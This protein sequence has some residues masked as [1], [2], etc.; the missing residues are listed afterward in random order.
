MSD[1]FD[2]EQNAAM[3][4]E[5]STIPKINNDVSPVTRVRMTGVPGSIAVSEE[6]TAEKPPEPNV[7]QRAAP[8]PEPIKQP[9]RSDQGANLFSTIEKSA[10]EAREKTQRNRDKYVINLRPEEYEKLNRYIAATDD[11]D[12]AE[13]RAYRMAAAMRY[14]EML[15]V[16][17]EHAMQNLDMYNRALLG[18]DAD[19]EGDKG[20][21]YAISDSWWTGVNMIRQGALGMQMMKAELTGDANLAGLLKNEYRALEKDNEAMVDRLPRSW[22]MEMLK[23]GAQSLPFTAGAA[24]AAIV[25][26]IGPA[27]SFGFSALTAAGSEYVELRENGAD[28]KTATIVATLSGSLQG[29]IEVALGDVPAWKNAVKGTQGITGKLTE[30]LFRRIKYAGGWNTIAGMLVR[31][32][33]AVA[34]EP[35]EE[36]IEEVLQ[37]FTSL[38]GQKLADILCEEYNMPQKSAEDIAREAFE[39]FKGG[40]MGSIVLSGV[41]AIWRTAGTFKDYKNLR[42][43]AIHTQSQEAFRNEVNRSIADGEIH[44][45]DDMDVEERKKVQNDIYDSLAADRKKWADDQAAEIMEV[46]DAGDEMEEVTVTTDTE[47]NETEQ[48]YVKEYRTEDGKLYTQNTVTD[49]ESED[50]KVT[51][52]YSVGDANKETQNNYGH[53]DYTI[54]EDAGKVTIRAFRMSEYRE[55]LRDEFYRDFAQDFAGYD[56]EWNPEHQR[57]QRIKDRLIAENP[58]GKDAGLNYFASSGDIANELTR[59]DIANQIHVAMPKLSAKERSAAVALLEAGAKAQHKTI[60][61][62]MS[63]TFGTQMFGDANVA[64]EAAQKSDVG[65][66]N[67]GVSFNETEKG[68]RA[69]IYAAETANFSTF[70]HEVAHIWR[71]QLT[72]ELKTQA[73]NAFGVE[74][75]QWTR[76]QEEQFAVGFE[77]Y[78]RTGRAQNNELKNLYQKLAEYIS[79]V[80]HALKSRIDFTKDIDDV[81]AQLMQGDDSI[82]AAAERAVAETERQEAEQKS[83]QDATPA[84]NERTAQNNAEDDIA[85]TRPESSETVREAEE[86]IKD[87]DVSTSE[88][89][90]AAVNAAGKVYAAS[91]GVWTEGPNGETLLDGEPAV[92]FQSADEAKQQLEA[93]RALYEG[94]DSWLTAPNGKQSNLD[95]QQWLTVRTPKF[96]QWFG[97][98]ETLRK[99]QILEKET[100]AKIQRNIIK[101]SEAETA[102]DAAKQWIK[103]HGN[104]PVKTAIGEVVLDER[105]VKNSLSHGF[106]QE[107]LDA[108][109]AIPSVLANGIYIG[110]EAD[111]DGKPIDNYYF[112]GRVDFD[113]E[114]RIVFCRVRQATRGESIKRFYVHEVFTEDEIKKGASLQTGSAANGKR[115]GGRALYKNILH[116]FLSVKPENVSK[117][118]DKNGEPQIVYHGTDELFTEFKSKKIGKHGID[119]G[120][121]FYFTTDINYAQKFTQSDII[122]PVFL[123]L[124]KEISLT[125]YTINRTQA[126]SIIKELDK[127][128][129]VNGEHSF[130]LNYGDVDTEG[131]QAL[132]REV[133]N[134]EYG[135]SDNDVD[136][137]GSLVIASGNENEV[138]KAAAKVL[139]SI[140]VRSPQ[141]DGSCH[142]IVR[143]SNQVKSATQNNGNFDAENPSILFQ[144]KDEK[145]RDTAELNEIE[146]L[147]NQPDR[148]PNTEEGYKTPQSVNEQQI[149]NGIQTEGISDTTSEPAHSFGN[150]VMINVLQDI[151]SVNNNSR[152]DATDILFQTQEQLMEEAASFDSWQEFMDYYTSGIVFE[153]EMDQVPS[154]ADARW[155]ETTWELA[156]GISPTTQEQEDVE[157]TRK[158]ERDDADESRPEVM[159]ALFI[160][161]IERKGEL[162]KFLRRIDEIRRGD[163]IE[164]TDAEEAVHNEHLASLKRFINTRLRHASFISNAQRIAGGKDLTE[165][166]RRTI[167]SLMRRASR[168]YRAIYAEIMDDERFAV[169]EEDSVTAQLKKA[170]AK[171]NLAD[172]DITDTSPEERRRIAAKIKNE[173]IAE[174]IRSGKLK[175]SEDIDGYIASLD[176]TIKDGE[177]KYN[178][179]KEATEEDYRRLSDFNQRQLVKKYEELLIARAKWQNKSDTIARHA[180]SALKV[181]AKYDQEWYR[182]AKVNY[183]T[184][185]REYTDLQKITEVTAEVQQAL[186]RREQM[187][188]LAEKNQ[189][190]R[191]EQSAM[192]QLK[193]LR[194]RLVKRTMRRVPFERIDYESARTL[195]A[196]QRIFEPNLEGGVNRWIGTEGIW[197]RQIWSNYQ[198]DATERDRI[199]HILQYKKRGG[200]LLKLLEDTKS[201]EAFNAWTKKQ[202]ESLYRLMPKENWIRELKL[203]ELNEE[204]TESIPLDIKE[205]THSRWVDQNGKRK[206]EIY[207]TPVFGEA[208]GRM[209][210]DALGA[211]MFNTLVYKPFA[212]WTTEEMENLAKKVDD[213]YVAGRN[214]LAAKRQAERESA[215]EIRDTIIKA[216]KNTGIVINDNDSEEVKKQKLEKI[217]KVL[218]RTSQVKGTAA[219]RYKRHSLYSKLFQ[220]Y[221]DANIHRIARLLD[222][223][224]EGTN[225]NMLY[226]E[227][228]RCYNEEQRNIAK[229]QARIAKAMEQNKIQIKDLYT[230]HTFKN[231]RG[232]GQDV[233]FTTDELLFYLLADRDDMSKEACMYGCMIDD[234]DREQYRL[235]DE[236][237]RAQEAERQKN[238]DAALRR[239]D[240]EAE[241][242]YRQ[243]NALSSDENGNLILPGTQTYRIRCQNLWSEVQYKAKSLDQKFLD[244]A[245]AISE[246][247]AEVFD[248][249]QKTCIDEFNQ[250]LARV[251]HYVPLIRLAFSGDTNENRVR[252]DLLGL[253]GD[254][255]KNA[256]TD[257]G[258]TMKRIEISPL[259]QRP[260]EAGL[261][262]TWADSLNRTEHFMAYAGYVRELNR[263]YIGRD[264]APLRQWM[265]SRYGKNMVDYISDYVQLVAN[266]NANAAMSDLDRFVRTMRGRTAPAYLAFKTS[267]ILKQLVT[268]PAPYLQFVNPAEYTGAALKMMKN[269]GEFEEMIK[270]KSAFMA[271][272]RMDPIIDILE[273]N[274]KKAVNKPAAALSQIQKIGMAGLE[275]IDWA[276]VAPGWYAVYQKEL[277]RLEQESDAQYENARAKLLAENESKPMGKK[278][279]DE[280][281]DMEAKKGIL[282]KAHIEAAAVYKADDYTRLCQPSNRAVDLAP[283][284][285]SRG[286]GSEVIRALLQ[287]QTALNVIWQ[288]IRYDIPYYARQKQM[289]NIVGMIGGYV[290]AGIML[291]VLA[292]A[293]SGGDDDD[294]EDT[295]KEFIYYGMTQFTDS[296]P[297]IGGVVSGAAEKAITGKGGR[298]ST[299]DMFPAL[300][301]YVQAAT[302]AAGG[303]WEKSAGRFTEGLA[304]TLGLPVSGGKEALHVVGIGDGDGDLSFHPEALLGRQIKKDR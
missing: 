179:L 149:N 201:E 176:K 253:S 262:S 208:I 182:N 238:L 184:L 157:K 193:E 255:Q 251:E 202:R 134:L 185:Y 216:I 220:W 242:K 2:G 186:K 32:G 38:G 99:K 158:S 4:A 86:A 222:N 281:I 236:D 45:F 131:I 11:P 190:R 154:D 77:D 276:C 290:A 299:T 297:I 210:Q 51:G 294:P 80:Y 76:E 101:A 94:T 121:G 243:Q 104:A 10:A 34:S 107:K 12:E 213:L 42:T 212:E 151:L 82:L 1:F 118:V 6:T 112:A 130:L 204:R 50:G 228:S 200:A 41:P 108:V 249:L 58:N 159:D 139:G 144:S 267:S 283:I 79:R 88:K 43:T 256:A 3:D 148:K 105:T 257:R 62:Y 93:V 25:P 28:V 211:D 5:E 170:G 31:N 226:R 265:E 286:K 277:T 84:Q 229:R 100:V 260:V 250:P 66:V 284:F 47:G 90:E 64:I 75:G 246:D 215:R 57:A 272:R 155:Y 218:G 81:Y 245:E 219:D 235:M 162:E 274:A 72:G 67:G 197:P 39:S 269:F 132:C 194:K 293:G 191:T 103:E 21:W 26:G 111:Y 303:N 164:S 292:K 217:N 87:P 68:V 92:L 110:M 133:L 129:T 252:A 273:E 16:P 280:Q 36:G 230:T 189:E 160:A 167:M 106:S 301:K 37:Y 59:I 117:V 295:L 247:Y 65:A 15:G 174:D 83:A 125:K 7:I 206:E 69:V 46:T 124:K 173:Q 177:E 291:G 180:A 285:R 48:P 91:R 302:N 137:L 165:R 143:E 195:I 203:Y 209:V 73:E 113:G 13:R 244:F 258:M 49:E 198:T 163:F 17:V 263:V 95:E 289:K 183:D 109:Q 279:S 178:E 146:E 128:L 156:K 288:N 231:F 171:Y 40:F 61:Q 27:M 221:G 19:R 24:A 152:T 135:A 142:F 275:W 123:N 114:E 14:S 60:A 169:A 22:L 259:N 85:S 161:T 207:R 278:M 30:Q 296:V 227:E 199:T 304:L 120:R 192:K 270:T 224:S 248:R 237:F 153:N 8:Q 54:D 97:D 205:E 271:A 254:A 33:I 166:A 119:D 96:K 181:G 145:Q 63:E 141:N 223:Y 233:T 298:Q 225:T 268:S 241:A 214:R 53:I 300:T 35:I 70:A 122:L 18:T 136:F 29:A 55:N 127:S 89:A 102:I 239:G 20:N 266:P 98:W 23:S 116:E 187:S 261:Y 172:R 56:I 175:I 147:S 168:D 188:V 74:K 264:A 240:T 126:L 115:L 150:P 138:T 287:F 232:D 78:L 44:A 9:A 196:I 71:Q 52:R 140:G 234:K 282:D